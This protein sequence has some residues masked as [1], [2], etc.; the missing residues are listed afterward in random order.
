MAK[1]QQAPPQEAFWLIWRDNRT[2]DASLFRAFFHGTK[3]VT[4]LQA[5]TTLR[6]LMQAMPQEFRLMDSD[7]ELV[8]GGFCE[9]HS[10]DPLVWGLEKLGKVTLEYRLEPGEEAWFEIK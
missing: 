10:R 5:G 6:S 9:K 3:Q 4:R 2:D 7:Y 1:Q 8:V